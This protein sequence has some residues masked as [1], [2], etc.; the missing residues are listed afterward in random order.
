MTSIG[1]ALKVTDRYRIGQTCMLC[2]TPRTYAG[3]AVAGYTAWTV[4]HD[5]VR[6]LQR[7]QAGPS[8]FI[9]LEWLGTTGTDDRWLSLI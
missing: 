1:P 8:R 4:D 6:L 7:R 9:G 2:P 5:P 3:T